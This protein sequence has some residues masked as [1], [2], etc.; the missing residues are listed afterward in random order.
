MPYGEFNL[1]LFKMGYVIQYQND[2]SKFGNLIQAKQIKEGFT[3]DHAQFTH[4]EISGGGKHS[5]NISPPRSK[6]VDIT[7]AHK[8]RYIRLVRYDNED[9]KKGLRY[10]VA[11]F[12]ASL[13]NRGYDF[14]GIIAFAFKWARHNNRFYFCS[15]GCADS[16]KQVFVDMFGGRNSDKIFPAD[17][18]GKNGFEI[19]WEGT[20]PN[21]K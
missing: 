4:V 21:D 7:K 9:F 1:D 5:I 15:E 12:S 11:Y 3:L 19:I 2:G 18:N 16:F 20:I 17:F 10:K 13:C 6:L 8:G 14:G